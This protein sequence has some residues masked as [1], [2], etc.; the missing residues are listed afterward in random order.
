[1]TLG[2]LLFLTVKI[3]GALVSTENEMKSGFFGSEI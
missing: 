3:F 1:M 2:L